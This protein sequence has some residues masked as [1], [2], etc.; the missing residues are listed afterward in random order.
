[1]DEDEGKDKEWDRK[2]G[3]WREHFD[4]KGSSHECMST[5]MHSWEDPLQSKCR[6]D[7]AGRKEWGKRERER[8][9]ERERRKKQKSEGERERERE[10]E[11]A[12]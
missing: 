4:C 5:Y 2:I 7:E 9:R 8:E 10:K 11:K 12:K 1:M 6:R 3:S